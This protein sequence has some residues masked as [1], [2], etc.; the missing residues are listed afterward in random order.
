MRGAAIQV[1]EPAGGWSRPWLRLIELSDHLPANSWM[2]VGG[3]MTQAHAMAA[4]VDALRPTT[5]VDIIINIGAGQNHL[6]AVVGALRAI[7]YEL[8]EGLSRTSPTHRLLRDGRDRVDIAVA[9]HLPPSVSARVGR[10]EV[11]RMPGG[12]Q[13]AQRAVPLHVQ[14]TANVASVPSALGALVLKGAAYMQ[15]SRD[16]DRHLLDAAAIAAT[17]AD[18]LR[19]VAELRGSDR[20]RLSALA[21]G[22]ASES[23]RAWT[24]LPVRDRARAAHSLSTLVDRPVP[25]DADIAHGIR[26]ATQALPPTRAPNPAIRPRPR[27]SDDLAPPP[28]LGR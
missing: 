12:T 8:V 18:P 13:A 6:H 17:I 7:G 14:G 11:F 21:R 4:A 10:R 19:L 24:H 3:L 2:L 27:H 15:D 1:P 20:K 5:D 28:D 9:D 23:H 22:L 16:A 26:T 25:V